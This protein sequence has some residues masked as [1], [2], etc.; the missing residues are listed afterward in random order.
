MNEFSYYPIT[1]SIIGFTVLISFIAF[2]NEEAKHKLLFYPY[3]MNTPNEYYR[4]ISY[5][6]I[7]ADYIHLFFNMF[8]LYSFGRI[9][10]AVLFNKSQYLIFY[11]TALIASAIFDFI[12]NRG[13]SRYGALGASGAVSA[14]VFSTIIFNPWER[15]IA[16]FGVIA[17]PNIVFAVL[18]LV[19]CAYM[20]KRGGDNIGHSAHL[21]GSVYGFVFTGI[22]HPDL[23]QSFFQQLMHPSF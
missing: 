5:G 20:A 1:F 4:F 14:V 18:Y 21:W 8:T 17:L 12:K 13:N 22:I 7:H 23:L 16:I 3:G 19:Y 10:E 15:A 2:N 9:A 6:F 11:I